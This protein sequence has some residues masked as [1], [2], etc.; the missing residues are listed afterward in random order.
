MAI[1]RGPDEITRLSSGIGGICR[2]CLLKH[3]SEQRG[4]GPQ[5]LRRDDWGPHGRNKCLCVG[6]VSVSSLS[7]SSWETWES[8]RVRLRT[9]GSPSEHSPQNKNLSTRPL[10]LSFSVRTLSV[11]LPGRGCGLHESKSTSSGCL[12]GGDYVSFQPV[13]TNRLLEQ[14]GFSHTGMGL[15]EGTV[16][17]HCAM[18]QD[19]NQDTEGSVSRSVSQA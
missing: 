1:V 2:C 11:H 18:G 12:L 7:S 14:S 15:G 10:S 3:T 19:I 5:R 17:L 8:R 9:T 6:R 16:W 13:W 4:G